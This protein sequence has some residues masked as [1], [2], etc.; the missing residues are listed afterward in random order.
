MKRK[1]LPAIIVAAAVFCAMAVFG[2]LIFFNDNIH[3]LPENIQADRIVIEKSK[4]RL[5][6]YKQG[7]IL[8]AYPVSLG[9]GGMAPKQREGDKLTPEG[10]YKISG[11]N[12]NSAY[13]LS[14]RINYPDKDDIKRA[15]AAGVSA[16][17]DI[18]IHGITNG[19]GWVGTLHRRMDWTQGCIAVTN[20]EIAEIWRVVPDGTVVEIKG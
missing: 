1:L 8:R 2:C 3:P 17:R 10:T 19:L 13:Y 18:M 15:R 12:S 7:E 9:R 11:R 20:A 4:R 16:G 5:T 6:L 14:L